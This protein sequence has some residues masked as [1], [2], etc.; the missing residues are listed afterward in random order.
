M[1]PK[2]SII[3]PVKEVNDY[4]RES[5][6]KILAMDYDNFEIVIVVDVES[7]ETW[8]KTRYVK[9]KHNETPPIKRDMGV[10]EAD[11]GIIAFM[12][13]DAY[14]RPDWLKNAVRH[15]AHPEV[16]AVYGPAV[17]PSSDGLWAQVSGEVFSSPLTSWKYIYRYQPAGKFFRELKNIDCHKC[18]EAKNCQ[19]S[20]NIFTVEDAPSV[21][22]LVKK[23]VFKE[24]GG[25][26]CHYYP[27]EDTKLCLAILKLHKKIV[28]DPDVYVWHHR[29]DSLYKHF[30]QSGRYAMHRGFFAKKYPETSLHWHYFIPT[31][32]VGFV[33]TSLA[34][35]LLPTS[36]IWLVWT[37]AIIWIIYAI[38]L[39]TSGIVSM[40][41]QEKLVTGLLVIPIIFLTHMV[42]GVGIISGLFVRNLER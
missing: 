36:P 12:D 7:K 11:G 10:A 1:N 32:F 9:A 4:I 41:R 39:L 24:A 37:C 25:F 17:T 42:Y 13:D 3:I 28:Y 8:P 6:P 20:E 29:R 18:K 33:I 5:I 40:L 26:D 23:D 34:V 22:L 19:A 35:F 14:P 2:V 15:F 30:Q 38:M 21:N 31:I 27:G 16:G